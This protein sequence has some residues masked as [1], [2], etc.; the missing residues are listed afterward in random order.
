[1]GIPAMTFIAEMLR[2][3]PVWVWAVFATLVYLG[4][5]QSRPRSVSRMRLFALPAAMLGLSLYGAWAG[6]GANP[7]VLP[8]WLCGGFLAVWLHRFFGQAQRVTY[9]PAARTFAVPGSWVPLGLMMTIFLVRYAIAVMI[10]INPSLRGN[11]AFL[12]AA[13]AAFGLV[14]GIF[15]A[16]S[17]RLVRGQRSVPAG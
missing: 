12:G 13:S 1:M 16:R 8:A 7:I 14:S 4:Y 15:I 9:S 3:T 6:L 17:L 10:A 5:L 2:R 11:A